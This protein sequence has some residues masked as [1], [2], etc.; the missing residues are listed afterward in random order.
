MSVHQYVAPTAGSKIAYLVECAH[1]RRLGPVLCLL[2]YAG[3][4]HTVE[5]RRE[6]NARVNP[7]GRNALTSNVATDVGSGPNGSAH[8]V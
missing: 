3:A 7:G 4:V 1:A 2:S 6:E 8:V 5:G